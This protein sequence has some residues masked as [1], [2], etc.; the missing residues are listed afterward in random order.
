MAYFYK[1]LQ[2]FSN[3]V[4]SLIVKKVKDAKY[5]A[6]ILDCTPDASQEEQM[7]LIVRFV[8]N[9][10][11]LPIVQEHWLEFLKVDDT[12]E[13]G[14]A[15][16]FQ[17]ALIKIDL[18]IDDIRGQGYDNGSNMSGKHKESN[19]DPKVKSEAE[20]LATY[21]LQNFEF[22]FGMIIWYRL[23]HVVNIVNKFLQTESMDIDH[24][25]NLLQGLVSFLEEYREIGFAIA[26]D[27]ATKKARE[28][29]IEAV[30]TEKRII[31]RKKQ[32]DESGSDEVKQSAEES[33][34]VDLKRLRSATFSSLFKSCLNLEKYLQH[35]G[36]SDISGDDLCSEL[37]VLRY[38][39]PSEATRAIEVL[40]YLKT[41]DVC[42]P[43]AYT[44]YQILLTI[45][46]TVALRKEVSQ[47]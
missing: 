33:F 34:R 4:R 21:E 16:E 12:T 44:A 23:L 36:R 9:S 42:F 14:L 46:V 13:L 47:N 5:F 11:N 22:L 10:A 29:G 31:R 38:Y 17:K 39:I 30:F 37:Q 15:T 20:S 27:E 28:M 45:P 41:L 19:E 18:N 7:S 6:V 40:Q 25:I 35:N 24:A 8:D 32:Y 3:Q 2:L 26:K 1:L 43:N